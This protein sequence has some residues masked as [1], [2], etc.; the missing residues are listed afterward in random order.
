MP[1][2]DTPVVG[3]TYKAGDTITFSGHAT[4]AEDGALPPSALTWEVLFHHDTHTHPFIDPFSGA[5]SGTM[6]IPDTGETSAEHVVPDP[7]HAT[8]S[9]GNRVEVT[10]DV[11][12]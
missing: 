9:D 7:P 11:R 1:V 5:T 8:D 10:R 12:R 3:T 2:I 6:T 4:D